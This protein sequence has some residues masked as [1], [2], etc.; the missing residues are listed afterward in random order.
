L[1]RGRAGISDRR[2]HDRV[3][4]GFDLVASVELGVELRKARAVD[5]A[6]EGIAAGERPA[7]EAAEAK[8]RVLRP[9]DRLAE[10]AVADHVD[11]DIGFFSGALGDTFS[12]NPATN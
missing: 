1:K 11:A 8:Q 9:A 4:Y 2:H 3:H 6:G 12:H 7:F 10:L 5:A